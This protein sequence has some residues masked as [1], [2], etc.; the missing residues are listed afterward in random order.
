[1]PS[2]CHHL[3]RTRHRFSSLG[4]QSVLKEG[5]ET[6]NVESTVAF[7]VQDGRPCLGAVMSGSVSGRKRDLGLK[8][9]K[10]AHLK[11]RL[12]DEYKTRMGEP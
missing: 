5:K 12:A 9:L 4:F 8:N 10:K 1:M 2:I 7:A 11:R 6:G 3:T